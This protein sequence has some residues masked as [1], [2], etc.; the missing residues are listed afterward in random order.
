MDP[1]LVAQGVA[2]TMANTV[3]ERFVGRLTPGSNRFNG[4]FQAGN[5]ISPELQNGNAFRVSPRVGAVYD[6]TGEGRTIVRGGFGIFYDR[7]QGNMVFDMISNAPGV[8]N[9][10]LDWGRLQDLTAAS[11]DP[12]PTLSL[13]P[14]AYDFKPPRV[15]Q[16]N[17]GVQHK[18]VQEVILDVAYVGSSSSDLLRQVQI[19][20]LPFG[21]TFQPPN[22]DPTRVPGSLPGSTALPNDFLRPFPGYGGIRMWDYSGYADYKGLQTSV[23]RRFDRGFMVSGFWVWSKVQGINSDDFAAGVPNLTPEQTRHLDY[24]LLSYDRTHNFT[25]NAIYQT[26]KATASK[27]LGLLVNDWQLSGVYRWTSGRP[28]TVGFSIPGIGATNLTGTDTPN[29]R[30]ALTCDPGRG[31][32]GDPYQQFANTSCFA[33]PQPGS[34]GD[35]TPRFFARNPPL[36]NLDLSVSK[37]VAVTHGAKFEIRLDMFN[38]LDTVQFT[39]VNSTA[40]FRSL[41]DR[42]ITNLPY[43]AQGN[44]VQRNGFGTINGVAPPRTLQLVTRLTF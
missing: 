22:Q 41:T 34:K 15:N 35:E 20:A 31:W 32:S 44:L 24:S 8:L 13:N 33:P 11:G 6:L 5:G 7:P 38:A 1:T 29:A 43:D 30:I 3:E 25:V 27:G 16:W 14:T 2:P 39:G 10:R 21:A 26:P 18:L 37:N 4:T 36:N 12:F 42:T 28:Y 19:N 9:S 23:T 17:V 40:N